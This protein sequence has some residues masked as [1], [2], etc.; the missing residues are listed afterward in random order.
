MV[1]TC[2]SLSFYEK[3][4]NKPTIAN[5]NETNRTQLPSVPTVA[6]DGP[7]MAL[8]WLLSGT[9]NGVHYLANNQESL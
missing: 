3:Y 4:T 1:R 9:K 5:M 6:Y 2:I 7:L 8:D